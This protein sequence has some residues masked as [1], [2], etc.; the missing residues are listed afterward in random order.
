VIGPPI[1]PKGLEP[2]EINERAQAWIEGEIARVVAQ[3]G[4]KPD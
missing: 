1:E 2:R 3:P 4:G